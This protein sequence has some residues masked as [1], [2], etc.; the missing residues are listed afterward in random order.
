VRTSDTRQSP[1]QFSSAQGSS[2]RFENV[3]RFGAFVLAIIIG[4]WDAHWLVP[5]I[6]V[7]TVGFYLNFRN[8][9]INGQFDVRQSFIGMAL[10][11]GVTCFAYMQAVG[12]SAFAQGEAQEAYRLCQRISASPDL[13][14]ELQHQMSYLCDENIARI[15]FRPEAGSAD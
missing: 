13:T 9:P 10:C 11:L 12:S 8:H 1:Q 6:C 14:S 15:A 2:D 3:Y 7:A 4:L 5:Y